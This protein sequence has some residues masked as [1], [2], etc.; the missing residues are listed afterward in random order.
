[1]K[2]FIDID[3]TICLNNDDRDYNKAKP[4]KKNIA[5]MNALFDSGH[6]ITY[7]SA[8]G[9]G[10][11][12]DWYKIT[13]DQ[14]KKWNVKYHHLILGEKPIY[15]LLIDDKAINVNSLDSLNRFIKNRG[16]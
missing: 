12:K 2:I 15:D 14:F 9:T 4:I 1:M 5:K 13:K 3:E 10:T 6:N 16:L 11:G 8:R 7:W